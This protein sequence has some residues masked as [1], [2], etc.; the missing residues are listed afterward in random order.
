MTEQDDLFI[1]AVNLHIQCFSSCSLSRAV[2]TDFILL[3]TV[4]HYSCTIPYEDRC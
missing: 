2:S 3:V 1:Q 4:I